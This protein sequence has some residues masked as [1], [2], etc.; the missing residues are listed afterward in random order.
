MMHRNGYDDEG[1][2]HSQRETVVD[3]TDVEQDLHQKEEAEDR[4]RNHRDR[5]V[6]V[7]VAGSLLVERR[8]MADIR[9]HKDGK[10][11]PR[12]YPPLDLIPEEP[13]E[14]TQRQDS[15][16]KEGKI[17]AGAPRPA[18]NLDNR[19]TPTQSTP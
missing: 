14:R 7:I 12:Q 1:G 19:T 13:G 18:K 10:R 17:A 16:G 6:S 15:C 8:A 2:W 11:S 4:E 5:R 9:Q 3:E